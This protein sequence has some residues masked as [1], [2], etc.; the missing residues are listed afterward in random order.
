MG[1]NYTALEQNRLEKVRR[2]RERGIEP[3]PTRA[4]RTHTSQEA[5][6]AFE[7]AEAAGQTEPIRATLTGRIRSM[8]P[9][10][11]ITFAH[12]EDGWGRIQ[13]FLR[14]NDIGQD[15][16]E[17]FNRDY[18]LG[19]F[20]QASGEMFRTRTGEVTLRVTSLRMLAK[21]I[22]PLPAAKD[23]VVDGE[24]VQH[25]TLSEPELRYRQRY[26]DLAV[27]P[28]VRRIFRIRAAAMRALRD[29]LDERGFL[30]VETPVL[31]PIYGGASARPFITYHN[32]LKQ[33]LYLRISFELYLKRLLVGNL[34]RVY[35]IGRDFR[36]EGVDRTHNP[37]FTQLEFYWAYADY[38]QVM[39]LTEQM[40]CFVAE[41]VLGSRQI[42][43]QGHTLDL[44]PPWRRLELRQGI[45]EVTG[46]DFAQHPTK[47][48]LMAA[49]RS[50][51]LPVDPKLTRGKLIE[52]LLS[53][54]LEPTLIQPTFV[55]NYPRDIS[56]LAKSMPD[57]PSMVERFEGYIA[58]MELC[59]AF[60]ELNDP[61]DQEARF[62]EMGRDY[63]ADD[64]ERHP[65]DEDYLRAMRYG[66]PPN[67]GFGMGIDRLAMLLTDSSNIREVI[68]FPHLRKTEE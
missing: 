3:Y 53:D 31:Q 10:G 67:G 51:D 18:D 30:E 5:I 7:K 60:T 40:I 46:I 56:P 12:I 26:A 8:R 20:V 57:D 35:E 41:R 16:L 47:E 54:Y 39:E 34:E 14:A 25:A 52:G 6:A 49:M 62:L 48:S 36:N 58:G 4:E 44:T 23:Q 28:D 37:E 27:N 43:Y 38:L 29:F 59:N 66:M 13:L 64:E 21:G 2:L 1:T 65:M 50:K 32:Q 61:L 63:A 17:M 19:D 33:E 68:L 24:I 22:T 11:K 42:T 9:M 45:L 15:T 55:Y